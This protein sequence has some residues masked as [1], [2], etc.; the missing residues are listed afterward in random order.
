MT[1]H[2]PSSKLGALP[3]LAALA[4]TASL[5]PTTVLAASRG[6]ARVAR[7]VSVTDSAHLHYVRENADST[8]IEEGVA[9][10]GLPGKVKVRL[11]VSSKVTAS[12]TIST[13]YGSL[14]GHGSGALHSSGEYASFGGSMTISHGTGRYTHAHGHGG[15]YGV[16]NRSTYATTVQ[17]TG[18]LTY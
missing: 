3:A 16:I 13:R 14:T 5:I 12:F 9:T 8:L 10:G 4:V 17:T 6:R 1:R 11:G 7:S 2:Q 18:T 15:F